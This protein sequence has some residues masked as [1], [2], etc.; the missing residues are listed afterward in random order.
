MIIDKDEDH[1]HNMLDE[2][3]NVMG[4]GYNFYINTLLSCCIS[5]LAIEGSTCEVGGGTH[6]GGGVPGG[7]VPVWKFY[8]QHLGLSDKGWLLLVGHAFLARITCLCWD[9]HDGVCR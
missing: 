3:C 7:S 4:R 1:Y 6:G 8:E 9:A 5:M 2:N